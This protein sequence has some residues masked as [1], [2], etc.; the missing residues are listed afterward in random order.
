[1]D[2]ALVA[3]KVPALV[4]RDVSKSFPEGKTDRLMVLDGVD[5]V[6]Q[7]GESV[8]LLGPSGSGKTT[9]LQLAGLLDRP[10]QGE[11]RVAG[12]QALDAFRA[13]I[14]RR[15][16][17][18]Y[19]YQFHHLLTEWTALENA[20]MPLRLQGVAVSEAED[21]AMALLVRLGLEAR[22]HHFPSALSGGEKQR[23]AIARALVHRPALVL[24]DEPTGNLDPATA[25]RAMVLLREL[26]KES[27]VALL[28]VTH[29]AAQTA[30][31]DHHVT[32]QH[33]CL[34]PWHDPLHAVVSAKTGE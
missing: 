8:A 34:R 16:A 17:I 20:M 5:L 32:L 25:E 18:G 21:R 12:Q 7:P 31:M 24:A 4:L 19:I 1:M 6:V 3:P 10:D 9:L 30:W 13:T 22:R 14:L 11:I 23:V 27:G 33:G 2:K 15:D 26:V 29:Q 28:M